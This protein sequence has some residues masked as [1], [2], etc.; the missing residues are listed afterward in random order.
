[1]RIF[2]NETYDDSFS[3]ECEDSASTVEAGPR[4]CSVVRVQAEGDIQSN[5]IVRLG[6][7]NKTGTFN[8]HA[9]YHTNQY[10]FDSYLYYRKK[11]N[12]LRNTIAK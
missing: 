4:C 7:Y 8:G 12:Y 6:V 9:L 11:G 2:Q 1:M 3:V 10:N 5:H